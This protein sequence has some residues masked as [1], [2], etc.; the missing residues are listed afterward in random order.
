MSINEVVY[1][2]VTTADIELIRIDRFIWVDK[3]DEERRNRHCY[4]MKNMSYINGL[5][6]YKHVRSYL[7]DYFV[8]LNFETNTFPLQHQHQHQKFKFWGCL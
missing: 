7:F 6:Q 2:C 4:L 1:F 5:K 3:W 8:D